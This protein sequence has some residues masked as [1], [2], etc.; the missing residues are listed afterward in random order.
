MAAARDWTALD[1]NELTPGHVIVGGFDPTG[2]KAGDVAQGQRGDGTVQI[3]ELRFRKLG[4]QA[5]FEP[6]VWRDQLLNRQPGG[7][8]QEVSKLSLGRTFPNPV[9]NV[10]SAFVTVPTGERHTV[11]V[12]IYDVRGKLVRTLVNDELAAG[13]HSVVW[14][15]R[16]DD[17]RNLASGIY[18]AKLTAGNETAERKMA[19]LK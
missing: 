11:K 5:A 19:L 17:G 1:A 18:F 13:P 4:D 12:S 15:G 7:A 8:P 16:D 14:N 10:T 9:R 3:A 6:V 2:L